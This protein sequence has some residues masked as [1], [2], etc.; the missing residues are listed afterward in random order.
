MNPA[1]KKDAAAMTSYDK[2]VADRAAR[3]PDPGLKPKF[4]IVMDPGTDDERVMP[5][6]YKTADIAYMVYAA[7]D[8]FFY[9][10][11]KKLPDGSLTTE[12]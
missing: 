7:M 10:V 9:D 4:V 8:G 12:F 5:G 1:E 6:E 11:M 2:A 3:F